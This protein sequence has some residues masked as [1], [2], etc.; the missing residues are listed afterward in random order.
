MQPLFEDTVV[1]GALL[2]MLSS[3][4]YLQ[5]QSKHLASSLTQVDY[6][7]PLLSE[8]FQSFF[9]QN[10]TRKSL[11]DESEWGT[12]GCKHIKNCWV[13]ERKLERNSIIKHLPQSAVRERALLQQN[14]LQQT[15]GVVGDQNGPKLKHVELLAVSTK[16]P[17]A[18]KP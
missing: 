17:G 9:A 13:P 7:Q 15:N 6:H 8:F 2:K 1:N 12:G 16:T 3:T 14:P 11:R 18:I 4:S 5:S 10:L